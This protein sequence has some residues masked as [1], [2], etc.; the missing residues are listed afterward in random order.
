[1]LILNNVFEGVKPRLSG[2]PFLLHHVTLNRTLL[3]WW[4]HGYKE[5]ADAHVG[6]GSVFGVHILAL[7]VR[8][9]IRRRVC[10]N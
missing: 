8:A 5:D 2:K 4:W 1:M 9:I 10:A 7:P 6:S 3:T